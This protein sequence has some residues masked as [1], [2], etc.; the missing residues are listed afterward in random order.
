MQLSESALNCCAYSYAHS[1]VHLWYHGTID[2]G[3]DACDGEYC[4]NQTMRNTWWT[5]PG[6]YI[7]TGF[8]FSS[9]GGGSDQRPA[10]TPGVAPEPVELLYNGSFEQGT[11]AGWTY[12]GGSVAGQ[13]ATESGNWFGRIGAGQGG[14]SI[15]HNR[16]FL[17]PAAS[18]IVLDYRVSTAAATESLEVILA[19]AFGPSYVL[20]TFSASPAGGWIANA[21]VPIGCA[22]PRGRTCT[23]TLRI[24]SSG[25]ATSVISIDNVRVTTSGAPAGDVNEDGLVNVA[26]L[27]MVLNA[28]GPCPQPCSPG[29]GGASCPAD[30]NDDCTVN[31]SDLLAVI[32]EWGQCS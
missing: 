16:F 11:L 32:N 23:L 20:G 10:L 12:H 24:N 13:I 8:Y 4:I 28:W 9:L 22:I 27:L 7:T 31:V 1:D 2:T 15:T 18:A 6:S 19:E 3:P 5:P 14:T 21:T 26:D 29:S 17:P 30:V 25:G